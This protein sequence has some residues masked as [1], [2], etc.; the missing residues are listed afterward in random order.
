MGGY[1]SKCCNT[2]SHHATSVIGSL[3]SF[4]VVVILSVLLIKVFELLR[5]RKFMG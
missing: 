2:F 1:S 5:L 3:T 4:I